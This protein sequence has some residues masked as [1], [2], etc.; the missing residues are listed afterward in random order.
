MVSKRGRRP[1]ASIAQRAPGMGNVLTEYNTFQQMIDRQLP[2]HTLAM[3]VYRRDEY[4]AARREGLGHRD[5]I[6]RANN[7]TSKYFN[8]T[9]QTLRNNIGTIRANGKWSGGA[10]ERSAKILEKLQEECLFPRMELF[11]EDV[12]RLNRALKLLRDP[13]YADV[14]SSLS[15]PEPDPYR[16]FRSA[17]A[18]RPDSTQRLASALAEAFAR[19]HAR[20]DEI[21]GKCR[22]LV[23]RA[24]TKAAQAEADLKRL[25]TWLD[26]NAPGVPYP[27]NR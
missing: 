10:L 27:G 4:E 15:L 7:R 8:C 16:D 21:S 3:Y 14:R 26:R 23:R 12:R 17:E 22:E 20:A 24:N 19:A 18:V 25:R 2:P 6:A 13:S 9:T 5:A 11:N 1:K